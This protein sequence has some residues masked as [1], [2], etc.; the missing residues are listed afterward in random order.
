MRGS[1]LTMHEASSLLQNL[2]EEYMSHNQLNYIEELHAAGYRVTAQR[3]AVLDAVCAAGDH[4][5]IEKII[6][7]ARKLDSGLNASTVYRAVAL[8]VQVGLVLVAIDGSTK[9]YEVAKTQP[10]HYLR[11]RSC[12]R[13]VTLHEET[14]SGFFEGLAVTYGYKIDMDHLV[15]DGLCQNCQ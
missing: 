1:I 12:G 3:Q 7:H 15:I 6:L 2:Q 9:V 4:A 14:T 11:C 8:F 5:P 10:H 13:M